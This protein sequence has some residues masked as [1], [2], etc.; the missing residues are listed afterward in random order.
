MRNPPHDGFPAPISIPPPGGGGG[1]DDGMNGG[2]G[3]G[4][5]D[6]PGDGDGVGLL[7]GDGDFH[8]DGDLEGDGDPPD[9]PNGDF[10]DPFE[11]EPFDGDF[12][13][14]DEGNPPLGDLEDDGLVLDLPDLDGGN[15]DT[16]SGEP[17]LLDGDVDDFD[18]DPPEG[19]TL[20]NPPITAEPIEDT[21]D[22][23]IPFLDGDAGRYGSGSCTLPPR[24]ISAFFASYRSRSFTSFPPVFWPFSVPALIVTSS[25]LSIALSDFAQSPFVTSTPAF[26]AVI[27]WAL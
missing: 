15:E 8:G 20:E 18:P 11:G 25:I 19:R 21:A 17:P 5:G 7:P 27:F 3:V 2:G 1:G 24:V 16:P 23:T 13:I 12:I 14:P 22:G 10:P 4:V 6:F 9:E 26:F